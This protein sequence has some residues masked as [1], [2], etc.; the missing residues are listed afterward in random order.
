MRRKVHSLAGAGTWAATT[1]LRVRRRT[2]RSPWR[3]PASCFNSGSALKPVAMAVG[4]SRG[5]ESE[6]SHRRSTTRRSPC[7]PKYLPLFR[8][9]S[10]IGSRWATAL[11][12]RSW[13]RQDLTAKSKCRIHCPLH[14][15]PRS[16]SSPP[17]YSPFGSL[18]G[19]TI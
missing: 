18:T 8:M 1:G 11:L 10:S 19:L 12:C 2:R 17:V 13:Q 3:A 7:C 5:C 4:S 6:R 16:T 9:S 15:S 14:Q